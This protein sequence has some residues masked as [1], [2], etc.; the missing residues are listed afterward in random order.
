MVA[1]VIWIALALLAA[2]VCLLVIGAIRKP[3][4]ELLSANSYVS[5]ARGFYVRSFCLI[6]FLATLA[7][8]ISIG[9]PCEEQSKHFMQ[10]LWWI[11]DSLSPVLLSAILCIGGYALLL[12]VLFAVLGRY[13][14]K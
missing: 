7:A 9:Q 4:N 13:R 3:M 11:L 8:I 10:C 12:T 6:I 14:D 2:A 1:L 5:P